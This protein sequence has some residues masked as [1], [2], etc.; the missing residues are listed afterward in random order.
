MNWRAPLRRAFA[1]LSRQL[2]ETLKKPPQASLA[3]VKSVNLAPM[4][5]AEICR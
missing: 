3:Q 5:I 2:A 1:T 4:D